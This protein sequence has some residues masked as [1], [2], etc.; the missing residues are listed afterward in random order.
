[1]GVTRL[2]ISDEDALRRCLGADPI[3]NVFPLGFLDPSTLQRGLWWGWMDRG[4]VRAVVMLV[5]GRLVV[6]WSPEPG[7][8]AEIGLELRDRSPPCLTVG[9]R[10][11]CDA[12]WGTFAKGETPERFYAQRLYANRTPPT[13]VDVPGFRPARP[14]EWRTLARYASLMELEDLG[15][16]PAVLDPE[17]HESVVRDRIR[18][19]RTWV[20]ERRGELV[21]TINIGLSTADGCQVGGTYVPPEHRGQ[22]LAQQ[23]MRALVAT[24][25]TRFPA[26]T[27]HVN[28]QNVAAVLTYE[29]TGFVRA[30]PFRLITVRGR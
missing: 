5:A 18:N 11:A 4:E 14:D 24:L 10:S 28:E 3:Q 21:F 30:A 20:I 13:P 17:A 2:T 1:M 29:R 26:I 16:D 27:L 25:R 6:P 23:G 15:R 22:G 12:F 8:A 7:H 19:E 9:P